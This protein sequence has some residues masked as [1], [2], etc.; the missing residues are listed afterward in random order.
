M[1]RD[2]KNLKKGKKQEK[3]NYEDDGKTMAFRDF[4]Q[5]PGKTREIF[6][7]SEKKVPDKEDSGQ[8][9][10][11]LDYR[12]KSGLDDK[13]NRL[14]FDRNFL[15]DAA[16][17]K[18]DELI[19]DI[20]TTPSAI[21]SG[22]EKLDD[23]IN[24][25]QSS[26]TSV[27]G[28]S[29]TGKTIFLTNLLLN[30]ATIY[31]DRYFIFYSLGERKP[32]VEVSLINSSGIEKFIPEK[33]DDDKI[34][35]NRGIINNIDIWNYLLKEY[36]AKVLMKK[37]EES[38]FFA[39]LNTYM[40]L[41]ERIKIIDKYS[42][43]NNVLMSIDHFDQS[44]FKIG[45]VFVDSANL[46]TS[47]ELYSLQYNHYK[48]EI[49]KY[50]RADIKSRPFPLIISYDTSPDEFHDYISEN[51]SLCLDI[52]GSGK[53]KETGK[54]KEITDKFTLKIVKGKIN[55]GKEIEFK[56]DR[57]LQKLL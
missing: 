53:K 52:T 54:S 36:S 8:F 44:H 49:L 13:D 3:N 56:Y 18:L 37:S 12:R 43:L 7:L 31:D 14:K 39:G 1:E 6:E 28:S 24:I 51:S 38:P 47:R 50:L 20:R 57:Q 2:K 30:I 16:P 40:K 22:F 33:L 46:L 42:E 10:R 34:L 21:L 27:T 48:G 4:D 23:L 45:A 17:F 5:F 15:L 9:P 32:D 19:E 29:K 35:K 55:C 26:I 25:P 11:I 41:S